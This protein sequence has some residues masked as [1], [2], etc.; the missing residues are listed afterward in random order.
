VVSQ[1]PLNGEDFII[2]K[3]DLRAASTA[4]KEDS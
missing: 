4:A 1:T 2:R 3:S